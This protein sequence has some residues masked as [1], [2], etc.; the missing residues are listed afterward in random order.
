MTAFPQ[1]SF[2]CE[3]G[4]CG[5]GYDGFASCTGSR[6]ASGNPTAGSDNVSGNTVSG[7]TGGASLSL[8][9]A[10][11]MKV[12]STWELALA[13]NPPQRNQSFTFCATQ[14]GKPQSCSQQ[15]TDAD[16]TW[17]LRG[18]FEPDVVG[19]WSESASFSN[20]ASA[21]VSFTVLGG[22]GTAAASNPY[23]ASD[24]AAVANALAGLPANVL[25]PCVWSG[26]GDIKSFQACEANYVQQAQALGYSASCSNPGVVQPGAAGTVYYPMCVLNGNGVLGKLD[27]YV[28]VP[29]S[30]LGEGAGAGNHWATIQTCASI[31]SCAAGSSLGAYCSVV[32]G[33]ANEPGGTAIVIGGQSSAGAS[34][35]PSV[36]ACASGNYAS[37]ST[38]SGT[39]TGFPGTTTATSPGTTTSGTGTGGGSAATVT[40]IESAVAAY[41]AANP[42]TASISASVVT[43]SSAAGAS[44]VQQQLTALQGTLQGLSA[45]AGS[46]SL[47]S[48]LVAAIQ[49]IITSVGNLLQAISA[50]SQ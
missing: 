11:Q 39:K 15:A 49:E 7:G 45:T 27:N 32:N 35:F 24:P 3:I 48:A 25:Q 40:G 26:A 5:A 29:M 41:R 21:S 18:T 6:P 16:G 33:Y 30:T 9:V 8:N 10:G 12:G 20:G 38:M 37:T 17:A 34:S 2:V 31:G 50:N 28:D 13:T 47:S 19:S 4:G 14:S 23:L 22:E 42:T 43:Q 46:G 36:Q 44:S 1:C